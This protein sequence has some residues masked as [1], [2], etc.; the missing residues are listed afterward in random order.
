MLKD[1]LRVIEYNQTSAVLENEIIEMIV[2]GNDFYL[3]QFTIGNYEDGL[4]QNMK[5][6]LNQC[7][8]LFEMLSKGL[9][10]I[11]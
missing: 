9:F 5:K 11:N 6:L 1:C 2:S 7:I 3:G 4:G 10:L 8:S